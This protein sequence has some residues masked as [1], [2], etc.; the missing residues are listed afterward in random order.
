[1]KITLEL[2]DEQEFALKKMHE[3]LN[4]REPIEKI[5]SNIMSHGII[6]FLTEVEQEILEEL[7]KG[8]NIA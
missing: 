7:K 1:M 6:A 5:A 4:G 2:T 3:A 8:D